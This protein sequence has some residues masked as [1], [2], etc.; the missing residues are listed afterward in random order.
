M[1][2]AVTGATGFIGHYIVRHLVALGHHCVCWRRPASAHGALDALDVTWVEGGLG[3][4]QSIAGLL[5]R[6]DAVVHGGL[7]RPTQAFRGAEGDI[8]HYAEMNIVGSLRLID[9]ARQRAVNKF[10]FISTCAVHE[11]ILEDRALDEAHPLWP[12]SHYGAYKAAVEKF[13]HSYGLNDGFDICAVRPTGVY[14]RHHVIENSKWYGL[15]KQVAAGDLSGVTGRG[16]K[17]VHAVDV[18]RAIGVLLNAEGTAGQAY[19]CY[20]MYVSLEEVARITARLT[21]QD[22]DIPQ[23]NRGPKHHID[24]SKIQALGLRCGGQEQLENTI[25]ELLRSPVR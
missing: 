21:G 20:D 24:T 7:Y 11:V 19:N 3:D 18:A 8:A 4:P 23:T 25:A 12:L 9:A 1:R 14:G 13:V 22:L 16:G 2:V 17:E 5:D 10:V 6:V 15:V